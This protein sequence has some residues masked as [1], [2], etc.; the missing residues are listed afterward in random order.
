MN[1][2]PVNNPWFT[3]LNSGIL[4]IEDWWG[5]CSGARASIRLDALHRVCIIDT[6][7]EL[8]CMEECQSL[9]H[10]V[11]RRLCRIGGRSSSQ[12][13]GLP[14]TSTRKTIAGIKRFQQGKE[15]VLASSLLDFIWTWLHEV[16]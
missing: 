13:S 16:R 9:M 7:N 4:R 1:S 5:A 10:L 8:L 3:F 15:W 12:S 6:R 14:L 2:R 11:R